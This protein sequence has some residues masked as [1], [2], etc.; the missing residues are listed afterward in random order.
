[1]TA[2]TDWICPGAAWEEVDESQ[3]DR[4]QDDITNNLQEENKNFVINTQYIYCKTAWAYRAGDLTL[5]FSNIANKVLQFGTLF[6][7]QSLVRQ[8]FLALRRKCKSFY[9][10]NHL[11]GQ[12]ARR[13][14]F[15]FTWSIIVSEVALP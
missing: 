12:A 14:H 2:A 7:F 5:P 8:T 10:N 11:I 4:N 1:M 15:L 6:L 3:M 9:S 13:E